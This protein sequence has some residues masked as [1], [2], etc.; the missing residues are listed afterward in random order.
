MHPL[1]VEAGGD[2]K[3]CSPKRSSAAGPEADETARTRDLVRMRGKTRQHSWQ[4][5][6]PINLYSSSAERKRKS[7]LAH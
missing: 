1:Y 7:K 6:Q 3:R 2:T 4:T 5:P